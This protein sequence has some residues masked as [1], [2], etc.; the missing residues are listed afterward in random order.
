MLSKISAVR[1]KC[2]SDCDLNL[3]VKKAKKPTENNTLRGENKWL[4]KTVEASSTP[5]APSDIKYSNSSFKSL[6]RSSS[7][8]PHPCEPLWTRWGTDPGAQVIVL[9]QH[10]GDDRLHHLLIVGGD[11][12]PT[13][14]WWASYNTEVTGLHHLFSSNLGCPHQVTMGKPS[15]IMNPIICPVWEEDRP[16]LVLLQ[17]WGD[18]EV[19]GMH[20]RLKSSPS[21]RWGYSSP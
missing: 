8:V 11:G 7:Q 4:S 13:L 19:N 21:I 10:R 1:E 3:W 6:T 16:S 12:S 18:E 20:L 9:L 15:K 14:R 2:N 17:H 5:S